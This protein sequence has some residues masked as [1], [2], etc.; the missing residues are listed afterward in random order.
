M[1][2]L[3]LK[4]NLRSLAFLLVVLML[5]AG[6]YSL[7][8]AN[9][10]GM[11]QSWRAAI[12]REVAK[13]G[14]HIRIG[15]L[16]YF[17]FQGVTAT[18]LRIY[19]EPEQLNEFSRLERVV[20]D[21]DKTKLARGQIRLNKIVLVDV[22]LV[23][24]V[25]PTK[26][27]SEILTVTGANGT[28]LMPGNR[29]LEVRNA[30]GKIA[31][32]DVTLNARIV[33][34]QDNGKPKDESKIGR[35]R[36]LIAKVV[37]ELE[38][39]KFSPDRPPAIQV[40]VDGDVN[41]SSSIQATAALQVSG[42]EQN[43]HFLEE[44][45]AQ[46]E[47]K[48]DLITVTSL[49]AIDSRGVLDGR[50]DYDIPKREGR[51]DISSSLE[52]PRLLKAWLGTPAL[53][54]I[55]IG[56]KQRLDA[57]GTFTLNEENAPSIQVTGHARCESVMLR[58]VPFDAV[59][60]SFSW[61]DG[62]LF[63]RDLRLTRADGEAQGRALVEWPVVRLKLHTTLPVSVYR[64][65]FTGLPLEKV[66]ENFS[67]RAGAAVDV[68]LE[69]GLDLT[70]RY[71]WA[72]T[73]GGSVKNVDY[74]GVPVNSAACKFTLNHHELDFYDGAV[75]FNYD[76][77]P[78]RKAFDGARAGA[79]KVGRIRYDAESKTVEVESVTGKIWVAPM[80]R[81]F[82]P[83]I[84]DTLEQYRF[85]QPPELTGS[86]RVDVTPQERTAL[87]I[88]FS[89]EQAADYQFLGENITINR[90]SGQVSIRGPVVNVA[91]LKLDAFGGPVAAKFQ[92]S[93]AGKLEGELSWSDLSVP[94]LAS[95]YR[96]PVKGGGSV[97]GRIDF[98]IMNGKVET[99]DAEGLL[100][101]QGAELFT[102][103]M[104]GPL[105]PLIGSVLN[106]E[107]AG[108]QQAKDAFCNFSIQDGIL[109]TRDFQT[110]TKSLNFAG[111]G[112]VNL[113]ERTVDMTMRMNARGL[114]QLIT[115]PLRSI[116]GLFQFRGTGPLKDP[117]WQSMKFTE[118]P[119]TQRE[120]LFAPPKARVIVQEL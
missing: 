113:N 60:S 10:T 77:Y 80:V 35:R 2:H 30:R 38:K 16:R 120:S 108:I 84:A 21:F 22:D 97:T 70:N 51:F 119:E 106:S 66:L 46:A 89:T 83:K 85:H 26:P 23:M 36:K 63:L 18:D 40:S 76:D 67:E 5:V 65:F 95:A 19:S 81:L 92:H 15:S 1:Y 25:D 62:D 107:S 39:W 72:Y 6:V 79:A 47:M 98:S 33:G 54:D 90:P 55:L 61:R 64:P 50:L 14:A 20:L 29:R 118:P 94:S 37:N 102:V 91:D 116:S 32:I 42:I 8:W 112:S 4:R 27:N 49:R 3:H 59:G 11:P 57:Q 96:F 56:G 9:H 117:E 110:S 88:T 114:L 103:P 58:G 78:L 100:A 101:V 7:W 45:T 99:M 13:Q 71:A 111:E 28:V 73:G 82:A 87:N 86:G 52:I 68:S 115:R 69:G 34:Y 48:G 43:G 104:F 53:K 17:P 41:D 74:R 93:G 31:G 105:T 24:P 75:E 12:E 109:S 44:I